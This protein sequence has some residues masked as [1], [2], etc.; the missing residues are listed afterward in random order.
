MSQKLLSR[1]LLLCCILLG[2]VV[3]LAAP[4]ATDF[5]TGSSAAT[6]QTQLQP[7]LS[8]KSVLV[9]TAFLPPGKNAAGIGLR[10]CRCSCGQPCKTNADCGGNVCAPGITCCDRSPKDSP[11]LN[12]SSSR[13]NAASDVAVRCN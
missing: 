11:W 13:K 3:A 1:T 10:T 8:L 2:A 5:V 9:A 6:I 12:R 7:D 4:A